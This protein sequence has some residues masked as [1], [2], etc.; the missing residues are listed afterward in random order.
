MYMLEDSSCASKQRKHL[1]VSVYI[2]LTPNTPVLCTRALPRA[3][4]PCF[5]SASSMKELSDFSCLGSIF[6]FLRLN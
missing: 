5:D 3:Q 4:I 6:G 1:F 2:V